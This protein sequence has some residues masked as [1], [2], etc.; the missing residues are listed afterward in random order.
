MV[1]TEAK[2]P[3]CENV[4]VAVPVAPAIKP[5]VPVASNVIVVEPE[6]GRPR[7]AKQL[8]EERLR[9]ASLLLAKP[10]GFSGFTHAAG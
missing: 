1:A 7:T 9:T 4:I 10:P 8:S 3:V 5:P 2:T 6:V